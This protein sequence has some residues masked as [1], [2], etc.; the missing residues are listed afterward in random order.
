MITALIIVLS[1]Y[2]IYACYVCYACYACCAQAWEATYGVSQINIR[3]V[4]AGLNIH[5]VFDRGNILVEASWSYWVALAS[6]EIGEL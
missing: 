2:T 5:P 6:F 1:G 3:F 4:I